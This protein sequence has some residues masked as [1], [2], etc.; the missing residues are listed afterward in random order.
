MGRRFPPAGVSSPRRKTLSGRRRTRPGVGRIA[1]GLGPIAL[2]ARQSWRGAAAICTGRPDGPERDATG[3]ARANSENHWLTHFAE[4]RSKGLVFPSSVSQPTL[5][6]PEGGTR[7]GSGGG[8][9]SGRSG[10]APL[11][12]P[13]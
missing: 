6:S 9:W 3:R 2:V 5:A 4:G 7:G 12:R 1:Y 10:P 11:A 8:E 13:A